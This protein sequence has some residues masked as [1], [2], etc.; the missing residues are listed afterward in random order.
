MENTDESYKTTIFLLAAI[1]EDI[2]EGYS[3]VTFYCQAIQQQGEALSIAT[4]YHIPHG[5]LG[6]AQTD[7]FSMRL[8]LSH[9]FVLQWEFKPY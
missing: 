7:A 1:M 3:V 4:M 6:V 8:K 5:N 2:V 9:M